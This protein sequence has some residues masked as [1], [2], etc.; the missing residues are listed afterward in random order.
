MR[1]NLRK[2]GIVLIILAILGIGSVIARRYAMSRVAMI[3]RKERESF[4]SEVNQTLPIGSDKVRVQQFLNSKRMTFIDTGTIAQE[5]RSFDGGA[6]SMIE[7]VSKNQTAIPL[8]ACRPITQFRF[9]SHGKLLGY[10]D[11]SNC[12]WIF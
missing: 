11:R 12:K 7:A 3:L 6:V 8:G 5:D 4:E 10:T 9:D 1:A 2:V